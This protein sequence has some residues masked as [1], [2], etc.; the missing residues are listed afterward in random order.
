MINKMNVCTALIVILAASALCQSKDCGLGIATLGG[1]R[2]V[3][4]TN[5][6]VTQERVSFLFD[7]ADVEASTPA[8]EANLKELSR[9]LRL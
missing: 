6:G 3:I 4:F 9:I 7:E 2:A 5:E 1:P 8:E